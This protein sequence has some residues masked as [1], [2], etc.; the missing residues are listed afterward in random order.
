MTCNILTPGHIHC[1]EI[2]DKAG[3]AVV[4]LLTRKALDGYK[5]EIMPFKDRLFIVETIAKAFKNIRVI[6][7][8]SLDPMENLRLYDFEFLA[9]GDGFE[10]SELDAMRGLGIK[11]FDIKF[12][13]E[14]AKRWASSRITIDK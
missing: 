2:L 11:R 14:K 13:G 4:G 7:Q 12:K 6:P 10:P 3:G 9:S 1:L 5:R 8:N